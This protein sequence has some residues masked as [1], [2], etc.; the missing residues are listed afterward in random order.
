[1][2]KGF[3]LAETLVTLSVIGVISALTLPTFINNAADAKI[4]PRLAKAVSAFEQANSAMLQDN[5]VDTLID[6]GMMDFSIQDT[7]NRNEAYLKH[8]N[9]YLRGA[10]I[11]E[12]GY[13]NNKLKLFL[14]KDSV[15]YQIITTKEAGETWH[16]DRIG[17]VVID[18]DSTTPII[19]S[20]N[21]KDIFRF[22][23]WQDGTLRPKGGTNW[24]GGISEDEYGG[25]EHWKQKCKNKKDQNGSYSPDY[26]TGS[27]FENNLKV[28]YR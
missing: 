20:V 1:M 3:T 8:L 15:K 16:Q 21:A 2:K 24:T 9:K 14:S 10:I 27:I 12:S 6:G 26:C 25:K 17:Q 22:S 11:T 4:G 5:S 13:S 23:F 28:L 18:I 7:N 19:D